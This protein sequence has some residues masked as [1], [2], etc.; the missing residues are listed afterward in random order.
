M[1]TEKGIVKPG[2]YR[3]F[4]GK[5]YR[6]IGEVVFDGSRE[7]GVLYVPLYGRGELTVRRRTEFLSK[8][9]PYDGG[10]YVSRFEF[11]EP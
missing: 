5:E 9:N 7:I 3:H 6:V 2:V 4:K 8:V 1:S 11:I 10:E